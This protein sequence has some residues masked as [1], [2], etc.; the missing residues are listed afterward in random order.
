MK[1]QD[2]RAE[3]TLDTLKGDVGVFGERFDRLEK[4]MT[5]R[6]SRMRDNLSRLMN[7]VESN[8]EFLIMVLKGITGDKEDIAQ[9]FKN[10]M[11]ARGQELEPTQPGQGSQASQEST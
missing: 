2:D 11:I 6:F 9:E 5:T 10:F 7:D 4:K 8:Q 1:A 3:A